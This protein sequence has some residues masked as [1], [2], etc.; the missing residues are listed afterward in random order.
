LHRVTAD[1]F[2]R[3]VCSINPTDPIDQLMQLR[4]VRVGWQTKL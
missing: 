3:C 1:Y 2:T 4:H